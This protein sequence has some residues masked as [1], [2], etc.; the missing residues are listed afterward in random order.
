MQRLKRI[1][2][3]SLR[4]F[5]ILS[6]FLLWLYVLSSAQT[7]IEKKVNIHFILPSNYSVVNHVQKEITYTLEGPRALVRNLLNQKKDIKINVKNIFRKKKMKYEIAINNIGMNFPF[8]INVVDVEPRTIHVELDKKMVKKIPIVLQSLGQIP[9]DHKLIQETLVPRNITIEGPHSIVK[10]IKEVKTLPITLNNITQSDSKK[11]TLYLL[12]DRVKYSQYDVDYQFE[13]QPTRA[14]LLI[15]NVPISFLTT[16]NFGHTDRRTVNLMVLAEN[17]NKAEQM[18]KNIK[19]VAEI[20]EDAT[21]EVEVSLKANMPL[22]LHLLEIIPNKVKV[23]IK[24]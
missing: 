12:D 6:G 10:N 1:Q 16:R 9:T 7:K 22:G 20:P 23:N 15:K 14:N 19:V 18:K 4:A 11:L 3:I 24:K 8:G 17:G 2:K 13:V 21:G 5:A